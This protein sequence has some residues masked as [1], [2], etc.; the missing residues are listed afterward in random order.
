[1]PTCQECDEYYFSYATKC[2]RCKSSY[3]DDCMKRF[4]TEHK[5]EDGTRNKHCENCHDTYCEDCYKYS[6]R[7]T[8]SHCITTLEKCDKC[9]DSF[10]KECIILCEGCDDEL[11]VNCITYCEYCDQHL[12][13]QCSYSSIE[14]VSCGHANMSEIKENNK[15]F[16]DLTNKLRECKATNKKKIESLT[17]ELKECKTQNKK[18]REYLVKSQLSSQIHPYVKEFY[19]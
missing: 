11:C 4:K 19:V 13:N 8:C 16:D 17:N 10:C 9:N 12:C 15:Q 14:Q 2:K 5:S 1:M 3:C 18:G 7:T 6:Y